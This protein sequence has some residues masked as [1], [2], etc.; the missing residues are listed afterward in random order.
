MTHASLRVH[1]VIGLPG[2]RVLAVVAATTTI[3]LLAGLYPAHR[4]ARLDPV[5]GLHYE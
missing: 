4:A 2:W 5:H 1:D 3:G